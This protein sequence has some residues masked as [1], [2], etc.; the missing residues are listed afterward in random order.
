MS[1]LNSRPASN[2]PFCTVSQNICEVALGI[3]A[4]V[5]FRGPG[6]PVSA[7]PAKA[8]KQSRLLSTPAAVDQNI[9]PGD[10]RGF[11]CAQVHGKLSDVLYLAP[12]AYRD[13]G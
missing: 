10:K 5:R 1:T 11:L 7:R 8:G 12:G 6:Q 13:L 2:A 9:R 3:T 4:M